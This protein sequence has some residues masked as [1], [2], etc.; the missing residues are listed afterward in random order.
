MPPLK[1]LVSVQMVLD[2]RNLS[3]LPFRS[4]IKLK[5]SYTVW[6]SKI[7]FPSPPKKLDP[8]L[9]LQEFFEADPKR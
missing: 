7:S 2:L 3:L 6:I 9:Y 4:L 1:N 8:D 5:K